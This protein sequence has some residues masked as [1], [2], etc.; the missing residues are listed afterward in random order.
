MLGIFSSSALLLDMTSARRQ[1]CGF[2]ELVMFSFGAAGRNNSS[3]AEWGSVEA[4]DD[5]AHSPLEHSV[6]SIVMETGKKVGLI[7]EVGSQ[8][9]KIIIKRSVY[10]VFRNL[11]RIG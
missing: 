11:K 3:E 7:H 1:L 9:L 5:G 10:C 6:V 2:E 4:R 8:C